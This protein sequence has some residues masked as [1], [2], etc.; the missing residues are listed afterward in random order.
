MIDRLSATLHAELITLHNL[1]VAEVR[2]EV[3]TT[4]VD[5][6]AEHQRLQ[7][8]RWNPNRNRL[9]LSGLNA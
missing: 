9:G 8:T 3:V 1:S 4:V 7:C 5:A 2:E 6:A